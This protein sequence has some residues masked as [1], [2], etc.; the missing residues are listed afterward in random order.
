[1][2][3][4]ADKLEEKVRELTKLEVYMQEYCPHD[5]DRKKCK[6]LKR[7]VEKLKAAL[8]RLGEE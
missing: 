1:M 5:I 2:T 4:M 7:E 3:N 6:S 8:S